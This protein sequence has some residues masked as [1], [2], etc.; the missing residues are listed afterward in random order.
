[1]GNR[2]LH[3]HAFHRPGDE[4]AFGECEVQQAVVFR[5]V[6]GHQRDGFPGLQTAVYFTRFGRGHTARGN[7]QETFHFL[8]IGG[9]I[10]PG[11]IAPHRTAAEVK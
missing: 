11:D 4:R 6:G 1:M 10:D 5:R 2:L 8:R 7:Q 9:G 3:Q